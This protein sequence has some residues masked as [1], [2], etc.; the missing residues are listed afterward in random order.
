MAAHP[1]K[2]QPAYAIALVRMFSFVREGALRPLSFALAL[3]LVVGLGASYA[4]QG[5]FPAALSDV[6]DQAVVQEL[7]Q[8]PL[9]APTATDLPS[10][11]STVQNR[12]IPVQESIKKRSSE[13]GNSQSAKKGTKDTTSV[14]GSSGE[15][16]VS[17]PLLMTGMDIETQAVMNAQMSTST[18]PTNKR[19]DD[20]TV[21][22]DR[23]ED[24]EDENRK[25]R[26]R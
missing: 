8:L 11:M 22:D 25:G 20:G 15:G 13:S 12:V 4:A 1:L 26:R 21:S 7:T 24:S 10:E 16:S 14:R 6:P 18:T 19:S 23:D 17:A 5:V 9:V 2:Q 3:V